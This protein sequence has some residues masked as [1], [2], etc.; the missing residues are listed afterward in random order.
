[1]QEYSFIMVLCRLGAS[2][3]GFYGKT[4]GAVALFRTSTPIW[5]IAPHSQRPIA[6]QFQH[7]RDGVMGEF[8]LGLRVF[9]RE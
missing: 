2:R 8:I 6:R 4:S 9:M 3:H 5:S 7:I 1:M